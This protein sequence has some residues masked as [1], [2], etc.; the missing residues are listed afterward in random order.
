ML[1]TILAIFRI[2]EEWIFILYSLFLV[3]LELYN[4]LTSCANR[5]ICLVPNI[6]FEKWNN[7]IPCID[8]ERKGN[9][10]YTC[11]KHNEMLKKLI[12][13]SPKHKA[14][15]HV[16]ESW[17]SQDNWR[18]VYVFSVLQNTVHY[19][20]NLWLPH[21]FCNDCWRSACGAGFNFFGH[22]L[23]TGRPVTCSCFLRWIGKNI[24]A[25]LSK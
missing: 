14:W 25:F 19:I 17:F 8:Q 15:L 20:I 7:P 1:F 10:T 16:Y 11:S 18:Y 12:I 2:S 23:L 6:S 21:G 22:K 3:C 13:L 5:L 4:L 24:D 9:A